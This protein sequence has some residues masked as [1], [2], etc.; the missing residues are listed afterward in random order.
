MSV[1]ITH[2]KVSDVPRDEPSDA[3]GKVIPSDWNSDHTLVGMDNLVSGVQG[4][5]IIN[6]GADDYTMTLAEAQAR[7]K[8]IVN[9][10]DGTKTCTWPTSSFTDQNVV[11]AISMLNATNSAVFKFEGGTTV[12][13]LSSGCA[14]DVLLY[15]PSD[16][17]SRLDILYSNYART[18]GEALITIQSAAL[19]GTA[20]AGEFEYLTNTGYFTPTAS[21]RGVM[22]SEHIT[23]NAA[24]VSLN[25]NSTAQSPFTTGTLTVAA[26]TTYYFESQIFLE[27]GTSSHGVSFVVDGTATISDIHYQATTVNAAAFNSANAAGIWSNVATASGVGGAS[28][29]AGRSITLKGAFRIT[30]GGTI[31]P[32]IAF[33]SAPGGTNECTI[34]SYFKCNAAGADTVT[35]V[36]NWS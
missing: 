22:V 21:N 33:S 20:G 11:Q 31:I 3:Q 27:N 14:T 23:S 35:T 36:G 29:N 15:Q 18:L 24:A 34:G 28:T 25:D 10:G 26:N 12:I 5:A 1:T 6:M 8:I 17:I 7:L 2:A 30:T 32:K 16:I 9:V 13:T 4:V 19:E